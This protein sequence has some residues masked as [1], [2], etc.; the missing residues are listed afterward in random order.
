[1]KMG[2]VTKLE[3]VLLHSIFYQWSKSNTYFY[4]V[5]FSYAIQIPTK[6]V[7]ISVTT[8]NGNYL[9]LI[10][11]THNFIYSL[12]VIFPKISSPFQ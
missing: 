5:Q 7:R 9:L 8:V 4:T 6:T 2:K 3:L 11:M 10:R 12:G 1:M